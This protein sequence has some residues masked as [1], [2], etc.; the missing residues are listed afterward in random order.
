MVAFAFLVKIHRMHILKPVVDKTNTKPHP[1]ENHC[2]K[3][4]VNK[5]IINK[6]YF[7]FEYGPNIIFQ[8]ICLYTDCQEG[9]ISCLF[10]SSLCILSLGKKQNQGH[11]LDITKIHIWLSFG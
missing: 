3:N 8:P 6:E 11:C 10:Y 7:L 5:Q 2:K 9:R 4:D 1:K